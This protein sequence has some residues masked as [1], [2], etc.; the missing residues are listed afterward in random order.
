MEKMVNRGMDIMQVREFIE[1]QGIHEEN[2]ELVL[3]YMGKPAYRNAL[4]HS[5]DHQRTV[6]QNAG[7]AQGYNFVPNTQLIGKNQQQPK[8]MGPV[9]GGLQPGAGKNQKIDTQ[10]CKDLHK[11]AHNPMEEESFIAKDP[12]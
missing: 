2:P 6:S 3:D 9:M 12:S 7:Y 4:K 11:V 1:E 10:T 5:F 8:P